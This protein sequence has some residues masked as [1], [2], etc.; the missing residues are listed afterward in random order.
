MDFNRITNWMC[1]RRGEG[2]DLGF[3]KELGFLKELG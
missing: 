2:K 1:G 3:T